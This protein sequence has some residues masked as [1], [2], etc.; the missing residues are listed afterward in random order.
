[1]LTAG[2]PGV[3]TR[4][5]PDVRRKPLSPAEALVALRRDRHRGGAGRYLDYV[6]DLG[7]RVRAI[8]L[9]TTRRNKGAGGIVRPAQLRWLHDALAAAGRRYVVVFSHSPLASAAG[10][11]RALALLDRD[12][13]VVAAVAGHTHRN[14][15]SAR[16]TAWG[17]YW[18]VETASLVDYPQQARAFRLSETATGRLVLETWLVDHDPAVPLAAVARELAYLDVQ[19]GRV[20]GA[21]GSR[22][23]RNVRLYR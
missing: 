10:G 17:G 5:T 20:S 22:R 14:R 6:F 3:A 2:I 23:D 9:D 13:R 4:V 21:A 15:I 19:G 18:L 1:L 12:Q 11:S 16:Q 7:P 8:V